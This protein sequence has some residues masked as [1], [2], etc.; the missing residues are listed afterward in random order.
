MKEK[1]EDNKN[2]TIARSRRQSRQ[3]AG[4]IACQANDTHTVPVTRRVYDFIR[5][6]LRPLS[7]ARLIVLTFDLGFNYRARV[8]RVCHRMSTFALS[9][10]LQFSGA[11]CVCAR[12]QPMLSACVCL[13]AIVMIFVPNFP[14]A[15][16]FSLCKSCC[17]DENRFSS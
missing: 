4:L 12:F 14:L 6:I 10:S 13:V 3:A 1:T 17:E 15:G 11:L 5:L 7:L 2:R 16:C 8:C 9:P